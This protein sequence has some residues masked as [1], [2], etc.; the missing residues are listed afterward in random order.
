M[1][2][3]VEKLK[4]LKGNH[5]CQKNSYLKFETAPVHF[6]AGVVAVVVVA[7]VIDVGAAVAAVIN[8]DVV[9]ASVID[10]GVGVAVAAVIDADTAAVVTSE[11]AVGDMVADEADKC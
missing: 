4:C 7:S 11:N 8:V 1:R 2:F 6:V 10:V 5:S 9:V 3:Y